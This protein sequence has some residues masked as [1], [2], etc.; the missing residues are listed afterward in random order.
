[1]FKRRPHDERMADIARRIGPRKYLEDPILNAVAE[2]NMQMD[3]G[4]RRYIKELK[5]KLKLLHY[6]TW[7]SSSGLRMALELRRLWLEY[8][9]RF[10]RFGPESLPSSFNVAE[11]FFRFHP[12]LFT[13]ELRPER[14][15]LL[16]FSHYLDWYTSG[17]FPEEP[18]ALV[19]ILDEGVIYSYD[20]VLTPDQPLLSAGASKL[21]V[22][23]AALIRYQ[24]ELSVL[25]LAGESPP[26]P[27]DM[28]TTGMASPGREQL[29]PDPAATED[30]RLLEG[31]PGFSRV[32]LA[33]RFNLANKSNDVRY[34]YLDQ[35][36][37]YHVVTDDLNTIKQSFFKDS[38]DPLY[39]SLSSAQLA[40]LAEYADLFSAA[41]SL[42]YAPALFISEARSVRETEFL[43][44]LG[45]EAKEPTAK[46][47]QREM[48]DSYFISSR[49]IRC[50]APT[51]QTAALS[52]RIAPPQLAFAT[53]GFWKPLAPGEIGSTPDGMAIV[54]KT[55]VHRTESWDS[56]S[57]SEFLTR[58]LA[59]QTHSQYLYVT[60]SPSHAQDLYK[61]GM[62][63]REVA[64]RISELSGSTAAPL[65]F[66]VLASWPVRNAVVTERRVHQALS[67][68]R[69]SPRREF[70]RVP[71]SI[72]IRTIDQIVAEEESS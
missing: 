33:T 31:A 64:D 10:G 20:F 17:A 56:I 63:T 44:N 18:G 22:A 2:R 68:F 19:D 70:F 39:Q 66:E 38:L 45:L 11:A 42:I 26:R 36:N 15:H 65:P 28:S 61:I 1:M 52:Y 35:G 54:G 49:T 5:G 25:V 40:E 3:V 43:T 69:V 6:A 7:N 27:A 13:F 71:L 53:E 24:D 60:R 37:S 16:T 32:I 21:V 23:G 34:L 51:Q 14:E 57:P 48:G 41:A 62:T 9:E 55:W 72:I 29:Q 58:Q 46:R 8:S 30:S 67:T 59:L 50:I 12:K 4:A 47:L